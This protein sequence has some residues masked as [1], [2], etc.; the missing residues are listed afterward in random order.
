MAVPRPAGGT[1]RTTIP[2]MYRTCTRLTDHPERMVRLRNRVSAAPSVSVECQLQFQDYQ[3][4]VLI[5]QM[6]Q[7]GIPEPGTVFWPS[8]STLIATRKTCQMW[9]VS[10]E[11]ANTA[12]PARGWRSGGSGSGRAPSLISLSYVTLSTLFFTPRTHRSRR[13][14]TTGWKQYLGKLCARPVLDSYLSLDRK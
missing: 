1:R 12:E 8:Q 3:L 10:L 14:P 11:S 5:T 13:I 2:P 4:H 6:L 7:R 9:S